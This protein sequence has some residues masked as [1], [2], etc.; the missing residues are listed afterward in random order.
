ML[1]LE[2]PAKVNLGLSVLAR[3]GD[4]FHE[5]DTLLARLDLADRVELEPFPTGIRLEFGEAALPAGPD[6]L[7]YRAAE[8]YLQA[9]GCGGVRIRLT[10]RIPIAAGL[11]GGSSD[12]AAVLRGL[13]Q[14][15][16][17]DLDLM[18]ISA[19][20]GSDVPFFTQD[21][22]A[23][24]AGGRGEKL[25][26]VDLP[27]LHLVLANPGVQVSTRD[28]Y[29]HLQNFS[30]RLDLPRLTTYLSE[31]R[32]PGYHNALQAGVLALAPAIRPVIAALRAAGLQGVLL[33]GSGATCFGIATDPSEAMR[34]ANQL[35]AAQPTWWVRAAN[36][37]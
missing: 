26:S 20:L 24:R 14:L 11:G 22:A 31:G 34:I 36:T 21:L 29:F 25:V 12:A 37:R 18:A 28:A 30:D 5:V 19:R 17:A 13:A 27:E 7:A 4:G 23:A 8:L 32:E 3:R 33:S 16:P 35:R 9:A 10:K 6:N 1:A 15:Y 2:A